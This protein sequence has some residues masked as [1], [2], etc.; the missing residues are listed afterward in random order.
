MLR[1]VSHGF[2]ASGIGKKQNERQAKF[3][4][5]RSADHPAIEVSADDGDDS[6]PLS[7]IK[8]NW[9]RRCI[10]SV[11]RASLG[12]LWDKVPTLFYCIEM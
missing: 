3:I 1:V 10:L 11:S 2:V 8:C 12:A 4:A 9:R 7:I 6:A 5:L